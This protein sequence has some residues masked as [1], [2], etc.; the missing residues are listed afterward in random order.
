MLIFTKM[1]IAHYKGI[2]EV[3]K[4]SNELELTL[5]D[6]K[7]ALK[8]YLERNPDMSY[9]C[10]EKKNYS[11]VGTILCGH[12]GRRGYIY[13][14]AVKKDYRGKSIAKTLLKKSLSSLKRSGM[15]RCIIMVKSYNDTGNDFWD[16]I[17]WNRRKELIMFSKSLK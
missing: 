14:L 16:K 15:E 13:H 17:G 12:D 1:K 8:K 11:I 7:P 10:I 2:L 3:W 4:E 5:G 6:S 9:V